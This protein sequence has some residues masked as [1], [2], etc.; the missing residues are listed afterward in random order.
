MAVKDDHLDIRLNV[1]YAKRDS[2]EILALH[3]CT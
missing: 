2:H 1:K 3:I